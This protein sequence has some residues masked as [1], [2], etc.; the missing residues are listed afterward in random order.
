[1]CVVE[2]ATPFKSKNYFAPREDVKKNRANPYMRCGFVCLIASALAIG[3]FACSIP[4]TQSTH[5]GL[6]RTLSPAQLEL[7]DNISSERSRLAFEGLIVGLGVALIPALTFHAWCTA[8]LLVLITQSTYYH[9]SPKS[10]WL[11]NHVS[12]KQQVDE[13]PACTSMGVAGVK[14][15]SIGA[16]VYLFVAATSHSLSTCCGVPILH[17]IDAWRTAW[18]GC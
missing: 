3:A 16:G 5:E 4:E 7:L 1:M 14:S 6:R 13:W 17:Q 9:I 11:L 8:S 2:Y 12:S 10:E 15:C 18:H